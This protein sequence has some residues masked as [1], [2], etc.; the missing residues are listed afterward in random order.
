MTQNSIYKDR[1][2][3]SSCKGAQPQRL[4]HKGLL[5]DHGGS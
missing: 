3:G 5:R 4:P 1:L 2:G